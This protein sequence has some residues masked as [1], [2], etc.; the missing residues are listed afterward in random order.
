MKRK[1]GTL[2]P[3]EVSVLR[4][5]S[6]LFSEGIPEFHGYAVA[7]VMRQAEAVRQLTAHG[8]LYRALDR[9]EIAGLLESRWEENTAGIDG[10]PRRRLYR[11]TAVGEKA[12]QAANTEDGQKQSALRPGLASS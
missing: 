1:P 8:T 9:M 4:A 11:L 12:L 10:R 5:G 6:Q 3:I 2:L 7:K